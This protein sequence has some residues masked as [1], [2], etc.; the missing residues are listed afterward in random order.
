MV[1]YNKKFSAGAELETVKTTDVGNLESE[2]G[3]DL[4]SGSGSGSDMTGQSK[5]EDN[6]A[7]VVCHSSLNVRKSADILSPVVAILRP[8][9]TVVVEGVQDDWTH[10]YT[11]SGIEG[12]SL[13]EY[14]VP[15][16]VE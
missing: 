16:P 12:Y 14:I 13:G 4:G 6:M 10:I 9:D 11:S 7:T 15:I 5:A 3:F 8:G 1:N 2:L